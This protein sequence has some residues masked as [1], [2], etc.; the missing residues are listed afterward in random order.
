M[1]ERHYGKLS[2]HRTRVNQKRQKCF[3]NNKNVKILNRIS[4]KTTLKRN[5]FEILINVKLTTQTEDLKRHLV[6]ILRC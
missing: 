2:T 1:S 4:T 5:Y 3:D 6:V